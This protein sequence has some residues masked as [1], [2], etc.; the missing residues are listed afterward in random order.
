MP[1]AGAEIFVQKWKQHE[2]MEMSLSEAGLG[3]GCVVGE[4]S[5]LSGVVSVGVLH[6]HACGGVV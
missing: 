3:H 4:Y 5:P 2:R 1:A 6:A